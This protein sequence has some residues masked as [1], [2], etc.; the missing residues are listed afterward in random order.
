MMCG[1][2][3]TRHRRSA[4]E[5]R[6][7]RNSNSQDFEFWRKKC[8]SILEGMNRLNLKFLMQTLR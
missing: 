6:I 7:I 4:E 8:E 5:A 1:T 2:C 3:G